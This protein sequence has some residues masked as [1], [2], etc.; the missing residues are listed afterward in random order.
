MCRAGNMT[1]LRILDLS[2]NSLT[3]AWPPLG[4]LVNIRSLDLSSNNLG[5]FG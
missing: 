5:E 4:D 3:G 1:E 2:S